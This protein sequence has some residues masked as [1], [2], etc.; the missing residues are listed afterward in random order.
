MKQLGDFEKK[1][2]VIRSELYLTGSLCLQSTI[3]GPKVGG[4]HLF[5]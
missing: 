5:F 2:N 3:K 4:G 1:K